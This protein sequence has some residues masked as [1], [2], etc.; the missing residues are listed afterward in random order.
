MRKKG[1]LQNILLFANPYIL[2]GFAIF[3]LVLLLG[4]YF[5]LPKIIAVIMIIGAI[6]LMGNGISPWIGLPMLMIGI[7]IIWNPLDSF[8]FNMNTLEMFAWMRGG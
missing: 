5:A 2:I 8:I 6:Y 3:I 7:L 4:L 1:F